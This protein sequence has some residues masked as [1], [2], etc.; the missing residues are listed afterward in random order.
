M[1][2]LKSQIPYVSRGGLKL[3]SVYKSLI[4]IQGLNFMDVDLL[5]VAL[6]IFSCRMVHK[7]FFV[8]MLVLT[9]S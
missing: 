9:T 6:L 5:L 4:L 2:C 3:E 1:I 7:E 8:L